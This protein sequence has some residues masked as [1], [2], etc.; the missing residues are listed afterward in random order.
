MAFQAKILIMKYLYMIA[1]I[2]LIKDIVIRKEYFFIK[3]F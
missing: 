2:L 3:E 1:D